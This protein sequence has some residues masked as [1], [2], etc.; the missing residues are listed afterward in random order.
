M[1]FLALQKDRRDG[2]PGS[3]SV[4]HSIRFRHWPSCSFRWWFHGRRW[5]TR[6]WF[7]VLYWSFLWIPEWRRLDTMCEKFQMGEHTFCWCG[8]RFCLWALSGINTFVLILYHLYLGFFFYFVTIPCAF[9]ENYSPPQIRHIHFPKL[10]TCVRLIWG[11]E[12]FTEMNFT[13]IFLFIMYDVY[14]TTVS[15]LIKFSFTCVLKS[16]TFS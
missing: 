11:D 10:R 7:C 3:S 15:S 6:C 14:V 9:C 13:P 8:G 1:L 12:A 16:F 2:L 5:G 4:W